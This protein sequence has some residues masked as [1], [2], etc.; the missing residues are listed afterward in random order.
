M[1]S[2][3]PAWKGLRLRAHSTLPHMPGLAVSSVRP[4]GSHLPNGEVMDPDAT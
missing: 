2:Q 3:D 1:R 4:P